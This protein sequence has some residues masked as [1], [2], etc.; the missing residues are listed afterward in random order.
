VLDIAVPGGT[1]RLAL[2]PFLSQ[3]GIVRADALMR[4]DAADHVQ[5][6]ADRYRTIVGA[7]TAG[8][9][10]DTVNLVVAHATVLGAT[11]GGGEREAHTIFDYAVPSQVF[12]AT[13]HYVALGHIHRAQKIAAGC[14]VWYSGSPLQLDFGETGNEGSVLIVDADAGTPAQVERVPIAAGRPLRTL[15]GT[16]AELSKQPTEANDAYLR[17]MVDEPA[18][19]G[20][21]D[22]VRELFPNAV[23]VSITAVAPDDEET[24]RW[25]I[26]ASSVSPKMRSSPTSGNA[27]F[28]ERRTSSS[29]ASRIDSSGRDG[30]CGRR[31]P[32]AISRASSSIRV[33]GASPHSV[34]RE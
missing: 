9:G 30:D 11:V 6:Y 20:L 16:L 13:T 33:A 4:K 26:G 34:S 23:E 12:P 27:F 10:E 18:R 17:V 15:R 14:P 7:L 22:E 8:F 21:A 28:T 3:R 1:A 29:R 31:R 2:L 25:S 32:Q 19:T 24:E 5:S